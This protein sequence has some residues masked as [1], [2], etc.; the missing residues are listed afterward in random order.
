MFGEFATQPRGFRRCVLAL[1]LLLPTLSSEARG[2]V[3]QIKKEKEKKK[4]KWLGALGKDGGER[5]DNGQRG[6]RREEEPLRRYYE[7]LRAVRALTT[8]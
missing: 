4:K 6:V 5:S 3:D 2:D 1:A 8:H 7:P